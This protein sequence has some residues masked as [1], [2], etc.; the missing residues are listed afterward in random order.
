VN[1]HTCSNCNCPKCLVQ[2]AGQNNPAVQQ[3]LAEAWAPDH[4]AWGIPAAEEY[5]IGGTQYLDWYEDDYPLQQRAYDI[6]AQS[7]YRGVDSYQ[8]RA[9]APIL[10]VIPRRLPAS[11]IEWFTVGL[12][13]TII[14]AIIGTVAWIAWS[15]IQAVEHFGDF[16]SAHATQIF[17]GVLTIAVLAALVALCSG[18]GGGKGKGFSGVFH[19]RMH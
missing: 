16:V 13:G 9:D 11:P 5:S 8:R 2:R 1:V 18:G 14:L 10:G 7:S 19:G 3:A 6:S 17:S 4:Q 12:A 15:V